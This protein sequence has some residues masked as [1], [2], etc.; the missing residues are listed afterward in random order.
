MKRHP[1]R[2]SIEIMKDILKVAINGANITTI[3]RKA[4]L[5]YSQA[6][7]YIML[8]HDNDYIQRENGIFLTTEKG[9]V[10]IETANRL[11]MM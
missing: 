11:D 10:F 5:N 8:A 7:H 2:T 4:R 9:K 6:M 1:K 3:R